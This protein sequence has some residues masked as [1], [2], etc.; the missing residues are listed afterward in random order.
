MKRTILFLYIFFV[1]AGVSF[2][3]RVTG[4]VKDY[5]NEI[6]PFASISVKGTSIGTTGNTEGRYFLNLKPG[7]YTLV[8]QHVG[9]GLVEKKITVENTELTVDFYLNIQRLTLK[10]VIISSN[11][12]DPAYEIIRHAIKKRPEYRNQVDAFECKVYIK[13]QLRLRDYPKSIFGQK[14]IIDDGDTGKSK[15]I[16]LSETVAK[17][18]FRK[19]DKEKVEVVS[20][21]VSGQA[22]SF[23]FSSPKFLSFYDNIVEISDALNPRGFIS[24]I[25]D[26][27]LD[28][29][30]Y[31]FLGSF[32]ENGKLINRI[33][34]I[35]KRSYEPLFNGYINIVEDDW[36]IHSVDL[37]LTKASQM[38]IADT[39]KI[40]HL[41]RQVRP[42]VWMIATQV[43]YPAVKLLGFDAT[44]SFVTVYS[45]YNI[46][47]KFPKK[48]FTNTI[49]T[50]DSSS[51]K[52]SRD[53]WEDIRP[54]PLLKEEI[55]DYLKKDSLEAVRKDPKYLDSLDRVRNKFTV[56]GVLLYGQT[57]TKERK[58]LSFHYPSLLEAVNFNTVE[59]WVANLNFSLEKRFD[60][61]RILT[62]N[63]TFRYGFSNKHFNSDLEGVYTFGKGYTNTISVA[64][65]KRV[66]QLNNNDPVRPIVN[67]YNTLFRGNNF[68]KIYEAWYGKVNYTKGVGAGF[69]L[70]AGLQY[71]DRIPLEN[72]DS[73]Y[74]GPSKN[75]GKRTPNYPVELVSENFQRHQ[76]LIFTF[77]VSWKPGTKYIKFPDRT[78]NIG[79]DYPLFSLSYAKGLY[80]VFGSDVDYDK[81]RFT[82][83]DDLNFKLGGVFSYRLGV[84][85]FIN[86][87]RVELPD[88]QHF[89]GNQLI[90]AS[91]YLNSF[92]LLP[93]YSNS[94]FAKFFATGNIEHHFNGFLTNKIPFV[95]K[96]NV[97]LVGGANGLYVNSKEYYYE[98]FG[99]VENILKFL[100]VDFVTGY[101]NGSFY[102]T[103]IRIGIKGFTFDNERN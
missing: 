9:Y 32:V 60:E 10:E 38:E 53:Y 52:R 35:P 72:T 95:K 36:H 27:A 6:L 82:V 74:W 85:G 15:M 21:R 58:K 24:P 30:R 69:T 12:E 100:R 51:N 34:V 103:G 81:W 23:G 101:R 45:D 62:L 3:T 90:I 17:Y 25:A 4:V 89:N 67:T 73:T 44:G 92:Q 86:N 70:R 19:P 14:V 83:S 91:P 66:F 42:D 87:H 54:I 76:A 39:L 13:G 41:Y 8:C 75:E 50:Y 33:H 63:P 71:Q 64:G 40:E 43:I 68:M 94:T 61:H 5:Q 37:L 56:G 55:E 59:G 78:I 28:F 93:Y 77:S 97:Y 1:S 80:K 7:N 2:A 79:S 46:E 11:A 16:Y 98:F 31:K 99:G 20:T 57:F 84:G 26:Q 47:P 88:Y 96:L 29:Y 65:G 49:V 18:S 22:E 102:N 48:Y